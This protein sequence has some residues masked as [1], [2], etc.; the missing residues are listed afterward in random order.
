MLVKSV[1][2]IVVLGG[3]GLV[4]RVR[5]FRSSV[6]SRVALH[7]HHESTCAVPISRNY[8]GPG[9]LLSVSGQKNRE[10]EIEW[11]R[12]GVDESVLKNKPRIP[13]EKCSQKTKVQRKVNE[14]HTQKNPNIFVDC[15]ARARDAQLTTLK[16]TTRRAQ[17]A[18]EA[19]R[20]LA[21]PAPAEL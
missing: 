17:W 11:W 7:M 12:D 1:V 5:F 6:E 9:S 20:P 13:R 16:N 3:E 4:V 18:R 2:V 10:G 8:A 19:Q 15:A 21:S 14:R